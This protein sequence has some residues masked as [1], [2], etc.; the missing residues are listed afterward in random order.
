MLDLGFF[1][2]GLESTLC[3]SIFI[4]FVGIKL[5]PSIG[6]DFAD[7]GQPS[8]LGNG[9]LQQFY[10]I[11]GGG[12]LKFATGQDT[13]RAIVE[14]CTHL[15]PVD[16]AGMPIKMYQAHAMIAF[17]PDP[18]FPATF[19]ILALPGQP[20]IKE[21]L[22]DGIVRYMDAMFVFDYLLEASCAQILLFVDFQTQID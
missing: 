9:L 21:D 20:V 2:E 10:G 1:Q 18:G 16:V 12:L 11:F 17:V 6:K 5:R 3:I 15:R 8:I 14:N 7:I 22:V 4:L 13:S 19:L